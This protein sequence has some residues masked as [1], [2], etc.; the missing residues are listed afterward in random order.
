[1]TAPQ[2]A[3][4]TPEGQNQS[5]DG[6]N[7]D[8]L[9]LDWVGYLRAREYRRALA[10]ARVGNADPEVQAALEDLFDLQEALRAR[11]LNLASR[12]ATRLPDHTEAMADPVPF[13]RA[14][15]PQG[16]LRSDGSGKNMLEA[17][18]SV[19][20]A[21]EAERLTDPSSLEARLAPALAEPLTRAEALNT[22]GVLHALQDREAQ[23]RQAFGEAFA[24]D[25]GHYRALTNLGNMALE[26]GDP[27]GAEQLYRQAIALNGD[28]AGAHH[29]LGV[30]LRKLGRLNDSVRAIKAGQRLSVRQTKRDQDDELKSN[31]GTQRTVQLLRIGMIVLVVVLVLLAVRGRF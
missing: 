15:D 27:A 30:A 4:P 18:V 22:L 16:L 25:P 5:A 29:N 1:M 21:A 3:S 24:H 8:G 11:R 12:L 10:A 31:P 9:N 19:L 14:L 26:G 2:P 6:L 13:R 17:A 20:V 7:P 28:Y 23:A